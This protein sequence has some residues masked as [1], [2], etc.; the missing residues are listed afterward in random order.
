M[1]YAIFLGN[2]TTFRQVKTA[3]GV[4]EWTPESC[5]AQLR[6]STDTY[7]LG[8][9]DLNLVEALCEGADSLLL[10]FSPSDRG[11]FDKETIE[12][13]RTAVQLGYKR[14]LNGAHA[15]LESVAEIA[16]MRHEGVEFIDFRHRDQD[17]PKGTGEKRKGIRILT[18]GTDCACGK[19]FTSLSLT[20]S[21]VKYTDEVTFRSTGQTGYLISGGGINNDTI[22]A[23]FLSGAAEWLSPENDPKHIDV[24][25]GQGSIRHPSFCGG[26]YS[27][28]HGSQPDYL[29]MCHDPSRETMSGV[30]RKPDIKE[31]MELNLRLARV[32]NPNARLLAISLFSKNLNHEDYTKLCDELFLEYG[33][34]TFDPV[35]DPEILDEV[36]RQFVLENVL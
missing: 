35:R 28:I 30:N 13:I 23:D 14:I 20:R 2:A 1:K 26:S 10:G 25:E 17:F 3:C 19:K 16:E 11:T 5:V 22:A 9:P 7:D 4:V 27:L 32:A 8:L 15:K 24:I 31:D 34:L 29:V 12:T 21:L 33:V 36:A 18:V 6:S